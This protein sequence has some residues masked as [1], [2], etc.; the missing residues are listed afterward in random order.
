MF[1]VASAI[2]N[3]MPATMLLPGNDVTQNKATV[4]AKNTWHDIRHI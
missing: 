2:P 1:D 4:N 3:E